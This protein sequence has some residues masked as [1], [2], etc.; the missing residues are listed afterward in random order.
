MRAI[1]NNSDTQK[2]LLSNWL[3]HQ[4]PRYTSYPSAQQFVTPFAPTTYQDWLAAVEADAALSLYVHI[5]YC[6]SLCWFCGC[7]TSITQ[8][9][10][11]VRQY[12]DV[13]LEEIDLVAARLGSRGRVETLHFG[14]GSPSILEDDLMTAVIGRLKSRFRFHADAEIAIEIDPRTLSE[15]KA[16]HYASLGFNRVSIG[17][18]SFDPA[19]QA[20]IHRLQPFKLVQERINWLKAAGITNINTDLIYGLPLQTAEKMEKTIEQTL[21]L[22][23]SR[24][25]LFS[26]AHVPWVKK[27]QNQISEN[28]LP[29][30][31]AK[32]DVYLQSKHALEAQGYIAIGIDHFA[33]PDDNLAK[34]LKTGHLKRNFQG[35]VSDT[36]ENLIGFG[37]S[38]ISQLP[39]GFAQ[40]TA[41]LPRYREA[42]KSGVL[43]ITRGWQLSEEDRLRSA[44]IS[45]LMCY[46]EVDVSPH[47]S[48]HG[49]SPDHFHEAFKRLKPLQENG[50]VT[51]SGS[52]VRV[53]TEFRMA[54]RM[55]AAAFDPY[56]SENTSGFSKVA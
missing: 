2:D 19:V 11:P 24:I 13:L 21:T 8:K 32:L 15:G 12:V 50:I 44:V 28:D 27:H 18:Q 7:S 51:V 23:P 40:N 26:Y 45:D 37:A 54:A 46:M 20:A 34:A 16:N 36:A 43:P 41:D 29:D 47:L 38:S 1:M 5:P 55:A 42:V 9:A 49:K 39:Q 14:G 6:R 4:A 35:Y 25:S 56:I 53:S 52:K 31:K 22:A 17:V 30:D 3:G 48:A 10:A 33:K